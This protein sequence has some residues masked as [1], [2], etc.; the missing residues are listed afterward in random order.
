MKSLPPYNSGK[1]YL[2]EQCQKININD[3][4]REVSSQVKD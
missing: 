3:Y 1:K 4:V 2:I